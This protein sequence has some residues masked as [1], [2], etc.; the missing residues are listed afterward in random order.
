[1][2][3][4]LSAALDPVHHWLAECTQGHARCGVGAEA[5]LPTRVLDLGLGLS[6]AAIRLCETEGNMGRYICLSYCWGRSEFIKT[7]RDNLERHKRGISPEALPRTF[8]HVIR[9]ARALGI[10]FVWIDSLCIIQDDNADWMLEAGRMAGV[11]RNS[12]ITIAPSWADSPDGGCFPPAGRFGV[13][14]GPVTVREAHHFPGEAYRFPLLSRAWTYQERLLAPRVLHFGHQEMLW[15]CRTHGRCECGHG[16]TSPWRRLE[17]QLFHLMIRSQS[18]DEH[19]QNN[20]FGNAEDISH[21]DWAM[22]GEQFPPPFQLPDQIWRYL[23]AQYSQL[24]LTYPTDRLP[25]FS[26]LA[27]E[28]RRDSNQEYLAGLWRDTLIP[29]MCWYR[30]GDLGECPSS[31]AARQKPTWSWASVDGAVHYSDL[32]S[33]G[34]EQYPEVLDAQCFLAGPSLTGQVHGG[35]VKL[36]C[37]LI[38]LHPHIDKPWVVEIDS[39][40]FI[41]Y[42]DWEFKVEDLGEVYLIPMLSRRR[43]ASDRGY[44]WGLLVRPRHQELKEVVRVGLLKETNIE[45]STLQG[46]LRH[47]KQTVTIV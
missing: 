30:G 25:A 38:P 46:F 13:D 31:D 29:D 9:I 16:N 14:L 17:K 21:E 23:V 28:K 20:P 11:Y 5:P 42:W 18:S 22:T 45:E 10:R 15:E 47:E 34:R 3:A 19:T 24:Q 36:S 44:F 6:D 4:D 33:P 2:S 41:A 1:M 40:I 8:R 12:Y 26:G 39:E 7:T 27:D 37:S 32:R 35:F 43:R